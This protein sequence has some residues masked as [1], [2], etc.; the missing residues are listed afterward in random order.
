MTT[1]LSRRDFL[2]MAA[3]SGTAGSFALLG[4]RPIAAQGDGTE[5][6]LAMVDWSDPVQTAFEEEIIPRFLEREI[7]ARA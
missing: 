4:I 5:F 7:P 3:A 1:K 2:R 6:S